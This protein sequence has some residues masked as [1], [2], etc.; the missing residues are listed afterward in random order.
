MRSAYLIALLAAV[1]VAAAATYA[2]FGADDD[3][4]NPRA[5][6][7]RSPDGTYGYTTAGA[8]KDDYRSTV[9]YF[10]TREADVV[11]VQSS[12]EG[13]T[14]RAI[15]SLSGCRAGTVV[16]PQTVTSVAEG[17]LKGCTASEVLFLGDYGEGIAVPGGVS[18]SV[19]ATSKG[20]PEA[21]ARVPVSEVLS[22]DGVLEC[23]S[24]H[25]KAYVLSGREG[26][27]YVVPDEVGGEPVARIC[28]E[29]FRDDTG[30]LAI[31]LGN[32][33]EIGVR[34]FYGCTHLERASGSGAADYR[35]ECFRECYRLGSLDLAGARTIGFES[36]RDC[37][38]VRSVAVPESVESIGGGAFYCCSG[39]RSVDYRTPC[40][41]IPERTFGYCDIRV[42][43]FGGISKVGRWAFNNCVNLESMTFSGGLAVLGDGAFEGC[44]FLFSVNLGESLE[45]IGARAFSDCV[46]LSS[47]DLPGT[48]RSIGADAF[49]HCRTLADARFHGEMPEMPDGVFE[50][51]PTTVHVPDR[52]RSSWSGY[53]GAIDFTRVPAPLPAPTPLYTA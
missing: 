40:G 52:F 41:E 6:E 37:K 50:G 36:F 48:L 22:G 1:L 5:S 45:S 39:L 13:Y 27:S 2:A 20:W 8:E 32:V 12:L 9:R 30:I 28:D 33:P 46:S 44:R 15:E 26:K 34:A 47:V 10:D 18:V 29:C 53:R 11:F 19:L 4:G 35:D 31:D 21:H 14:L 51:L 23:F 24:L 43:E 17:A 16:V 49:L 38:A 3:K 7:Y 25:G 42:A